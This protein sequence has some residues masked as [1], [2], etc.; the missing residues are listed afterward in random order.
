MKTNKAVAYSAQTHEG[1]RAD[2][3]QSPLIELG[4]AVSTCLLWENTF[5]EN[6]N[7]IAARIA[8]LC[9]Q[10]KPSEVSAL[11]VK[12]RTDLKLRHV[13]LFLCIQ[14]LK[15]K[16]GKIAGDTIAAVVKRPDEMGE[17][18]ALYRKEK[19]V[20]LAAQLKKALAKMF[21][22]FSPY[23]LAKWNGDAAVKLRDVMFMVHPKPKDETQ[24]AVWKQLVDGTL[25][26]PDTW[27]VALSSGKDK[28]A[29]WTRLLT[30]KKLGYM[31]LLMNLRNMSEAGIEPSLVEQSL[32]DG[33]KGSKALPFRFISAYKHAPQ[34]AQALSDAMEVAVEG[35]LAGTTALLLDVSGSMDAIISNKGEL[36]RYETAAALAVLVRGLSKSCRIFAYATSMAEIVNIK[37]LGL[38]DAV[39]QGMQRL[40]GS[41]N[42][43]QALAHLQMKCPSVDRVIL[44]TD[45][46]AHD[47][48]HPLWAPHGYIINVA[49]YAPGLDTG[50]QW[51][52]INGW[53]ERV[54]D[55]IQLHEQ[56]P[57][58]MTPRRG[59]GEGG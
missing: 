34:Y 53:S 35:E 55:W 46:Q 51:A 57:Q 52:R 54:I 13:P 29:T 44:L 24:A 56:E 14:L 39:K 41:T 5:Y 17:L 45:E 8:S 47:G 1:G 38:I 49:P 15:L 32:R 31:A 27:E 3:H 28:K 10:V 4:R 6:G 30:E 19:R 9:A 40:G 12:A 7:D 48:I 58:A 23:Q 25:E 59:H 26:S 33:A 43:A 36:K 37:G 22:T 21:P 2:A 18:I 20:P 11:A 50:G 42:T 16:A